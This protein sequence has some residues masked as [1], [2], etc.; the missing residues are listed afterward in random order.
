MIKNSRIQCGVIACLFLF[1]AS[2]TL[3]A[4]IGVLIV[5]F[6]PIPG[7][8]WN[9]TVANLFQLVTI[10]LMGT[11]VTYN[12]TRIRDKSSRKTEWMARALDEL[13]KRIEMMQEIVSKD[14]KGDEKLQ[15]TIVNRGFKQYSQALSLV[16][17]C[18]AEHGVSD[19]ENFCKEQRHL[20]G[21]QKDAITNVGRIEADVT[22]DRIRAFE[23]AGIKATMAIAKFRVRRLY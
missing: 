10:V 12:L 9:F 2:V 22:E 18:F 1:S 11:V 8:F 15:W 21:E 20:L 5:K 4:G 16:E 13:Q 3:G 6:I 23:D 19:E 7:S 14:K 17:I